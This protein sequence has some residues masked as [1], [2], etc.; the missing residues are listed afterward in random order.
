MAYDI[1]QR[2]WL[3]IDERSQHPETHQQ[4]SQSTQY[5]THTPLPFE[6]IMGFSKP[7][8]EKRA[9][10]ARLKKNRKNG[11]VAKDG[12][13]V[14]AAGN[15]DMFLPSDVVQDVKVVRRGKNDTFDTAPASPDSVNGEA[16]TY[17]G[18]RQMIILDRAPTA[19]ESAYAGPPRYDWIDIVSM[20]RPS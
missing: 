7:S 2:Q 19:E 1:N 13:P 15:A 18:Q 4:L 14:I 20:S 16:K 11:A 12:T 17:R 5:N 10:A 8:S 9:N 3:K 6:H